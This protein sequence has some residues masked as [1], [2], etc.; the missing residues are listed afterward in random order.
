[1]FAERIRKNKEKVRREEEGRKGERKN[2]FSTQTNIIVLKL[3]Y[4][5]N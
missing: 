5:F 3:N 4:Y 2:N 1:M